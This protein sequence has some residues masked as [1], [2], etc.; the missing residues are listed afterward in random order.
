MKNIRPLY[1]IV[2]LIAASICFSCMHGGVRLNTAGPPESQIKGSYTVIFFG[3]N[4]FNDLETIAFLDKE[5]DHYAFEPYAPDFKYRI[6]KGVSAEDALEKA[7]KFLKCSSS[8]SHSQMRSIRAA[9]GDIFGYE[10]RPFYGPLTY[11]VDD[12][13]YTDYWVE[14]NKVGIMIRLN[15]SIENMLQGGDSGRD[16]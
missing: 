10:I 5:D 15:T 12:V 6:I 9:N 11:G 3:C 16:K 8:F 13:L 1:F 14:G 2:L 4:Y 7:N